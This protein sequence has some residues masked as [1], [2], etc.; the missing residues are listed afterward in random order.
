MKTQMQSSSALPSQVR[1]LL[2]SLA[3]KSGTKG[4][5]RSNFVVFLSSVKVE[6]KGP[7]DYSSPADWP[8]M[9]VSFVQ[10]MV[11]RLK[12]IHV[13][14]IHLSLLLRLSSSW[15]CASS[16]CFLGPSGSSG[17]PATGEICWGS[18]SGSVLSS[19][20]A[21]WRKLCF[22]PSTRASATKETMVCW[23]IS[24]INHEASAL[25]QLWR[26][27]LWLTP[28]LWDQP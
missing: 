13:S 20:W 15:S 3:C 25:Q 23:F 19:S 14:A 8:L 12:W 4:V 10:M 22:T 27:S 6:M 2:I 5:S 18:S 11:F 7:H 1:K 16:T 24:F 9:M 26:P 21:C 17:V 28:D